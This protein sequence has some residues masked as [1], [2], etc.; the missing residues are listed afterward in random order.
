MEQKFKRG[1]RVLILSR[2]N[3]QPAENFGAGEEAIVE[4]SNEERPATFDEHWANGFP[5]YSLLILFPNKPPMSIAWYEEQYLE[6]ICC[7][8]TKGEKILQERAAC[9]A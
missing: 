9:A 6:L 3:E 1:Y 4:Y 7:N 8:E 5:F 2:L